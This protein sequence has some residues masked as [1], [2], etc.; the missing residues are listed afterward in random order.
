MASIKMARTKMGVVN[1]GGWFH[2]YV[3]TSETS[4]IYELPVQP[5]IAIAASIT[6]SGILGFSI[7]D[8][9]KLNDGTASFSTWDGSAAINLAVTG[10]QLTATAGIVE[11][12]VCVKTTHAS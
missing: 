6:G 10:F 8:P 1:K 5:V 7:D 3:T 11:A 4:E 2:S 12:L 9:I